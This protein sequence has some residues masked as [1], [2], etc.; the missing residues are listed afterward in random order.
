MPVRQSS[1]KFPLANVDGNVSAQLGEPTRSS[2]PRQVP[3]RTPDFMRRHRR[4]VKKV[5]E[6]SCD[7]TFGRACCIPTHPS[8]QAA[9]DGDDSQQ[10]TTAARKTK[11]FSGRSLEVIFLCSPP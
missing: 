5:K 11:E 9:L 6:M 10:I 8:P 4:P 7:G 3:Q 2:P 1:A